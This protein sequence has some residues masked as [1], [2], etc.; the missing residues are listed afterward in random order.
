M[1]I[2][3]HTLSGIATSTMFLPFSRGFNIRIWKLMVCG[4]FGGAFPDIDAISLWSKFDNTIGKLLHLTHNGNDIYFSKYWYSHHGFFHSI[5]GLILLVILVRMIFFLI[6]KFRGIS[7]Q[8]LSRQFSAG[9]VVFLLAGLLH[10]LEDMITPHCVWGGV[11]LFWPLKNYYGGTGQIWWWNN[12]DLF[13]IIFIT[14][15]LNIGLSI[16][17]RPNRNFSKYLPI[18]VMCLACLLFVR[19]INVRRFEYNY[20]GFNVNYNLLEQK[21]IEEQQKILGKNLFSLMY[22]IDSRI[23]FYF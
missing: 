3:S 9:A 8:Y 11:R 5:T 23:P 2:L 6:N 22:G 21:S 10:L 17:Y 20:R 13:L 7:I 14:G 4:A 15:I 19:Q 1:D 16:F 12:Y 18:L